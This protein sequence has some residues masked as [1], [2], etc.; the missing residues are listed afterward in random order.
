MKKYIHKLIYGKL[1]WKIGKF[2]RFCRSIG[3]PFCTGAE[4]PCFRIGKRRRRNTAYVND[5]DNWVFQCDK[6][7]KR[8]QEYWKD[9]W[10][11]YYSQIM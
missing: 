9:M 6:C 4:G 3:I 11:E 10:H 8:E 5:E 2:H 1:Y 7:F